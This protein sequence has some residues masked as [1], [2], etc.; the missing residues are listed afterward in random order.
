MPV[1]IAFSV[2]RIAET[3]HQPPLNQTRS[4]DRAPTITRSLR[5]DGFCHQ[6]RHSQIA[7]ARGTFPT[8]TP[9]GFLPW[10]LSDDGPSACPHCRD[11]PSSETL[12]KSRRPRTGVRQVEHPIGIKRG[13]AG[14]ST[15]IAEG[16]HD[17][18]AEHGRVT[19]DKGDRP[20][21]VGGGAST[22]SA[23]G[24]ALWARAVRSHCVPSHLSSP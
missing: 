19:D 14:Y 18:G 10:G 5:L 12:H 15:R 9:R 6:P 7:I 11:G 1:R 24:R 2:V 16:I 8:S 13:R 20:G 17:E 4:P 3:Q 22:T 21:D 23:V